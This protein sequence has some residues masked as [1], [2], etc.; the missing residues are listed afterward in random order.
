[1]HTVQEVEDLHG[2]R[3]AGSKALPLGVHWAAP[4]LRHGCWAGEWA[5]TA[6]QSDGM[7]GHI[8]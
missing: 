3:E 4:S 6:I 7:Q 5:A 2:K 8:S 1:V